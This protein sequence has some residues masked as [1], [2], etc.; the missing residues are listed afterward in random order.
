[1]GYSGADGLPGLV[2]GVGL[3]IQKLLDKDATAEE[4]GTWRAHHGDTTWLPP[5]LGGAVASSSVKTPKLS[6]PLPLDD[7]AG[8]GTDTKLDPL[9]NHLGGLANEIYA[10]QKGEDDGVINDLATD[11]EV[12]WTKQISRF[13]SDLPRDVEARARALGLRLLSNATSAQATAN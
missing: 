9:G 2:R 11:D 12:K 13:R 5:N 7:P 8:A 4:I 10:F 6:G 1:M 3:S